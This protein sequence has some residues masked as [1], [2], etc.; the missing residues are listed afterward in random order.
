MHELNTPKHQDDGVEAKR[1]YSSPEL[2]RYGTIEE[3]TAVKTG[4][5]V[6]AVPSTP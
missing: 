6:D 2:V 5:S 4:A 3:L 1:P